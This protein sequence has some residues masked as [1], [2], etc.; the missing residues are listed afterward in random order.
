[1]EIVD[2]TPISMHT[3]HADHFGPLQETADKNKC[4]LVIVDA[5]TKFVW[6]YPCKSTTVDQVI[7]HLSLLFNLF[8]CPERIIT[9]RGTA[10]SSI[11][12]ASFTR[13]NEIKHS[14]TAV[15][16]PWANGAVECVNRFLKSTLAKIVDDPSDWAKKLG[17]AQY[18]LNN[19][20]HKS[21]NTTPS[22][23]LLGCDQRNASDKELRHYI[24][25]LILID[26]NLEDERNE[27]RD[28]AKLVNR[29]V[30][31]YNKYRYVSTN[32]TKSQR[33]LTRETLY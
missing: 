9:D 19:T 33:N 4:I 15:V 5:Y 1:M 28:T 13:E 25:K 22:K 6:L 17:R 12:F 24:E 30:Q 3:S 21:I 29:A 26:T 7:A 27:L 10:F 8:G 16:S 23:L 11:S 18:I 32:V 20:F 31:N 14:M 2:I